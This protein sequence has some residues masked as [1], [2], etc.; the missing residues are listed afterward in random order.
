MLWRCRIKG[1]S[2]CV[3]SVRI[4]LHIGCNRVTMNTSLLGLNLFVFPTLTL[5]QFPWSSVCSE[6][7]DSK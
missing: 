1:N 7:K 5:T 6:F 4:S 2:S 3:V